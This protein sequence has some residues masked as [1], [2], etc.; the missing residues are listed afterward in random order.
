[1]LTILSVITAVKDYVEIVHKLVES[2]SS[3]QVANYFDLGAIS[4]YLILGGKQL[5]SDILSFA[6]FKNVWSIPTLIPEVASAMITEVS[7]LDGYFHNM[8]TILESP[9]SYG[10]NNFLL[11]GLEKFTIGMI[12]S[13]FL[14][15]P[16]STAHIITLRR[17]VM[18]GLEAGYIAGLGTIAG[19]VL[20]IGSVI[21]GLRFIVIPWLS[22]DIF[23][24]ILGFVLL[25]KYMWDSYS[26]RRTV[27]ED[28]SKKKIFLLNFLLAFTEQTNIY[29]FISNLSIGS[30]ST[31]LESFA[32]DNVYSFFLTH[33]F[34]LLGIMVGSLSLLQLTCWFWENPAF[35]LYMW[36]ISS[37][38]VTTGL[39]YKFL[40]FFFLYLTMICSISSVAYF[41]LDYTITN[42]LGFVYEDR[43]LDQKVLLETSFI[44][45]KASDRNTRRNRGRHGRRERWKRRVRR[46]RT[47]DASLYD[48]GIYDLFTMED[49]NYGF[50]RFWLRR[51]IRNHRVRFRF[52]PG[53]WMRSFKKQLA[54][55]RLES[56]MGP[57]V[58]F[59]RILFEQVYHPSFHEYNK[60]KKQNNLNA[61]LNNTKEFSPV[62]LTTPITA[63]G[64]GEKQSGQSNSLMSLYL[65]KTP[66]EQKQNLRKEFSALR[67][68]VRK[69][70]TRIKTNKIL[71]QSKNNSLNSKNLMNSVSPIKEKKW[72]H[73]F[74]KM[75]ASI[76][77]KQDSNLFRRFYNQVLGKT[78]R[79]G[80]STISRKNDVEQKLSKKELQVSRYK[81][82]LTET[83]PTSFRPSSKILQPQKIS[84]SPLNV[85]T[86]SVQTGITLKQNVP[87]NTT[88]NSS[89]ANP[90]KKENS[91]QGLNATTASFYKTMTL[92]HP[93]KFYIQKEKSFQRKLKFYGANVY[94]SFSVE[95]N[96]P[97]FRTM[98]KRF[99]YYYKPTL[100][101]ERTMRTA[102]MRKARRKGS[103]IPR[104]LNVS[105]KKQG[106]SQL[107]L[108]LDNT[109]M[110]SQEVLNTN[111][112]EMQKPTHF[113]SL[114]SKRASRYRYQIYKD[115]LQH[116]YYSPFNRLFLKFDVDSFIRRQPTSHFLTKNEENLLN[117]RRFLLHEHYET[118]RWYTFMQHYSS[119]KTHMGGTKSFA[120]RLYNQQFQGTFKK[121]RHLFALTPSS[122]ENSILRFDQPLY[123]EFSNNSKN[124]LLENSILHEE[125]LADEDILFNSKLFE[126]SKDNTITPGIKPSLGVPTNLP[127]DTLTKQSTNV[128]REYLT[129]SAP[130][131]QN[132]IRQLIAE[133]NY[134][135]LTQFLYKGEK[136]RGKMPT[137]NEKSYLLQEKNALFSISEKEE[138]KNNLKEKINNF[139]VKKL[140]QNS[141]QED[142]WLPL[143]Q[144]CQNQLYNQESLRLYLTR[145]V[146]K[147]QRQKQRQEKY[148]K[149][150]L[151]RIKNWLV[152]NLNEKNSLKP[153]LNETSGTFKNE[154]S[155]LTTSIQKA[156]KEGIYFQKNWVGP[157]VKSNIRNNRMILNWE[158]KNAKNKFNKSILLKENLKNRVKL[159]KVQA[160]QIEQDLQ[161]EILFLYKVDSLT[162][163]T[164][165]E[166]TK[167]KQKQISNFSMNKQK[168]LFLLQKTL[169][170]FSLI[171][172]FTYTTILDKSVMPVKNFLTKT[173]LG[174]TSPLE[175]DLTVWRQQENLLSKRKKIRKTLKRLRNTNTRNLNGLEPNSLVSFNNPS[176][177]ASLSKNVSRKKIEN[178]YQTDNKQKLQRSWKNW[179]NQ[180]TG[181]SIK[182]DNEQKNEFFWQNVTIKKF[183]RKRSRLRRYRRLK[184]RG[185]IKKRTLGEKLK[186]QFR[187]LKKYGRMSDTPNAGS[188][189]TETR[190]K[191]VEI[192]Q[193]ITKRKYE[194]KSEFSVREIKQR[195]TK[196]RKHRFW[197]KHKKQK[198]AQNKR[199][200]R[201]R[202]R[203][204]IGKI[205]VLNKELKR[206]KASSTVKKWWWE[207]FLP[208][209]KAKQEIIWETELNSEL[210]NKLSQLSISEIVER[211]KKALTNYV[212]KVEGEKTLQ[213][214]NKDIKPLAMPEALM[215]RERLTR[216]SLN[217]SLGRFKDNSTENL[218]D[219]STNSNNMLSSK[220][221]YSEKLSNHSL[222]QNNSSSQNN[223]TDMIGKIYENVFNTA[224]SNQSDK[225]TGVGLKNNDSPFMVNTNPIPFYAGWDES[226]RKF[227]VTNRYLSSKEA[228]YTTKLNNQTLPLEKAPLKGM[229]AATTLYWQVPFTTYDPDQFFALGMDGFSPIG[230]RKF[231]F[232]HSTQTT[233]PL[234]VK[235]KTIY[236]NVTNKS[237]ANLSF[238]IQTKI[239]E[240]TNKNNSLLKSTK[241]NNLTNRQNKKNQYRKIQKRYKRVKK[242]PRPPVWFPSGPLTNQ[243]LPVHYIYVF[244]KRYRLPRDRYIRRRLRRNKDGSPLSIRQSIQ[245]RTDYTLRRRAKPKRKYHRKSNFRKLDSLLLKRRKFREVQTM[246]EINNQNVPEKLM[247]QDSG[248]L[249]EERSRPMSK[250][251]L[252]YL[253]PSVLGEQRTLKNKSKERRKTNQKQSSENLRVRQLRRRIQRQVIRPTWR[254]KPRAGGFTWPGDYLRLELVNAPKLNLSANNVVTKTT[255]QRKIR[256]K[257][258]RT[259]QEWQIQ[260]KKFLLQKHNLKVLK[261]RLRKSNNFHKQAKRKEE[262]KS[263]FLK[264]EFNY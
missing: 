109:E 125:L 126:K 259:I 155:G 182:K 162:S 237:E 41:G 157:L 154:I 263:L 15:L 94:R 148:L 261:N 254:Y 156:L 119:M 196:Q 121:V 174:N 38:K 53:P 19:N 169:T 239:L 140:K 209:F 144:K 149:L 88:L 49:L 186:R 152:T 248:N 164:N 216:Q 180:S 218:L 208:T 173:L 3:N 232:R 47:F 244:Y 122:T 76:K 193:M 27:L 206:V 107:N 187:L 33:G 79:F 146:E 199:K 9:I 35:N 12:N 215:I 1:M 116:W 62:D 52:F 106:L 100:R 177:V 221:E 42:P 212:E 22:F 205:R 103:R 183:K 213:I 61:S 138:L 236:S 66:K 51:K 105:K 36:V 85:E 82:F 153:S 195:R 30:D 227:V 25:V 95:N 165:D 178:N 190:N 129:N 230:W 220:E 20:W 161:K 113:Y 228:G 246:V 90:V 96:A 264:K 86:L 55:P 56:F 247:N 72:K 131:R 163:S 201:K 234:L 137:T 67:K 211:D 69:F 28:L 92:L 260:P 6:W 81:S 71:F 242:H 58:E 224:V 87:Y 207:N 188:V 77:N 194:P 198:Y 75:S 64:I 84:E 99:F 5:F 29:P 34:Y 23:R 219:T 176:D 175:K 43:L 160:V 192:F 231:H 21:F 252:T 233:K 59:F 50:D 91:N 70:N 147:R 150:R 124:S 225:A 145:H 101:W 14:C 40:N 179:L 11:Y 181:G 98:M 93:L 8:F 65:D 74:S 128:I 48:Q 172:Q 136:T 191:K 104:K 60:N 166:K 83:N 115:V 57:R 143:I 256:K 249:Y 112:N 102:T 89:E 222:I 142:L 63:F 120:S 184:G 229:N 45:T 110:V 210:K 111:S 117:L 158:N 68:F 223:E 10:D 257:K 16:T 130:I 251:Q 108:G 217:S 7:V 200:Q 226:L 44:N 134:W 204:A 253:K 197:K 202:R 139:F 132:L 171:S 241:I 32:T 250:N 123:N 214:G 141:L 26:E 168:L 39:Y 255:K 78:E 235:T 245:T 73:I 114:V 185:P 37:F 258:R 118:L 240:T 167:D 18:Q 127:G 262:T 17:F 203:Y 133:K 2:D 13:I 243:V 31:I 189:G 238:S 24:Y 97:Y 46:Y 80:I 151:E 54:K 4:T 159:H 135:E 170:P